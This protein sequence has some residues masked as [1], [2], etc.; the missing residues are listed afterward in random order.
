MTPDSGSL[1]GGA[2]RRPGAFALGVLLLTV[3]LAACQ[4]LTEQLEAPDVRLT[5]VRLQEVN[6]M[7]QR[8]L[9]D[10]D[11]S[12]PNAIALPVRAVNYGVKL[13]GMSLAEGSS[14]NAFRIPARGDGQFSVS[15]EMSLLQTVKVLG[16]RL[17][18]GGEQSLDYDVG[19][20]VEVD[21]PFVRPLPFS[22]TG[23]VQISRN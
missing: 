14:D 4:T 13:G 8:F 12:N 2:S 15:V 9:L 18:Q 23:S 7:Q 1:R 20:S 21:L 3:P 11:V 16:S 10:F 5:G 19:G 17:L 6:T 22:S